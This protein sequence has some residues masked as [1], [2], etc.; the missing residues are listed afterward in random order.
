MAL[1]AD[2]AAALDAAH[3]KDVVHRDLKPSNVML[4]GGGVKLLDFGLAQLRDLEH[5]QTIERSTNSLELTEHGT[6][7]GTIPYTAPEQVEGLD[8]DRRTDIFALG[9]LLYEMCTG[10]PP[11]EGR[12]RA[13]LIAAILTHDPQPLSFLRSGV[14]ARLDRVVQKCLA[15]DPNDRWQSAADLA[16]ALQW[17]RDDSGA[18]RTDEPVTVKRLPFDRSTAARL[19]IGVAAGALATWLLAASGVVGRTPA[20]PQFTPITFRDRHGLGGSIRTG[21]RNRHFQCRVE[22]TPLRVVHD[23]AR[24]SRIASAQYL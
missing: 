15:K 6:V 16:A 23:P 14:P 12:S 21:R 3:A 18:P 24:Q 17:I 4:V 5:E 8:S 7:L 22:R 13:S 2:I 19:A 10:R 11:F 1:A 20:L 9:V